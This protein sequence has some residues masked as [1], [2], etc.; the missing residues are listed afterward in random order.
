MKIKALSFFEVFGI[1][2]IQHNFDLNRFIIKP[3]TDVLISYNLISRIVLVWIAILWSM[4]HYLN[5]TCTDEFEFKRFSCLVSYVVSLFVYIFH[6]LIGYY[7]H[8]CL[9]IEQNWY[10]I[11]FP[12]DVNGKNMILIFILFL[13]SIITYFFF[14]FFIRV[15]KIEVH[16]WSSLTS[17]NAYWYVC[18]NLNISKL[19]IKF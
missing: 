8:D 10:D 12:F 13:Y 1:V 19:D 15:F 6:W 4:L 14:N 11:Y 2:L 9:L 5:C 16:D 17:I 7:N 18:C 3:T